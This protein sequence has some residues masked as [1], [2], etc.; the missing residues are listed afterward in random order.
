MKLKIARILKEYRKNNNLSVDCVVAE[1]N[2]H[3]ISISSKTV[4]GYE[5]GYSQPNADMFVALCKIYGISSLDIFFDDSEQTATDEAITKYNALNSSG[6]RK[7]AEYITD[8][9]ENK[10]YTAPKNA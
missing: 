4:Y 7:A 6:K 8:L 1:L 3:N 9:S 10:K 2:K 5:N